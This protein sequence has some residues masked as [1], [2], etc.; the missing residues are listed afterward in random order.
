M[1]IELHHETVSGPNIGWVERTRVLT[2]LKTRADGLVV[3]KFLEM[4]VA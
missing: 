2:V 1:R 3:L 4:E